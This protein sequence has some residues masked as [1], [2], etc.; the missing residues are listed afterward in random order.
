MV[1]NLS[2]ALQAFSAGEM[3]TAPS[4]SSANAVEVE[5]EN[6]TDELNGTRAK[7]VA[8]RVFLTSWIDHSERYGLGYALSDGTVGVHFRDSTSMI[9]SATKGTLDYICTLRARPGSVGVGALTTTKLM[10][11]L[12]RDNYTMPELPAREAGPDGAAGVNAA[13]GASGIPKEL[14][15]KVKVMKYF[16]SEIM[17]RLYGA[18]GPLTF[19]D[20]ATATG[21]TF[22]H[23][24]YRCRDAIVFRLSNSTVQFNFYDHTKLLLTSRG[25]VVSVIEPV[26]ETGGVQT[27]KSW[28]LPEFVSIA[29]DSR[30]AREAAGHA[31]RTRPLERK[32]V[33]RLVKKLRY[34]RDILANTTTASSS[35]TKQ[36]QPPPPSRP[37]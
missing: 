10:D 30:S 22:L 13:L 23:K 5:M 24:W 7:P 12:R 16:E 32:L 18:D 26:E 14:H 29:H 1:S 9:L 4:G 35:S 28:T 15:A 25:Q 20:A 6:V 11:Q 3:Y 19:V 33:R 8:P 17:E 31:P 36:Q 27:I 2:E 37:L 21:M 34:A